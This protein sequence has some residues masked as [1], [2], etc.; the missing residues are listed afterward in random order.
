MHQADS[1]VVTS[2]QIRLCSS[3]GPKQPSTTYEITHTHTD[4]NVLYTCQV[5]TKRIN[6]FS[7]YNTPYMINIIKFQVF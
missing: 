1:Q 5:L 3:I 2:V 6:S 7:F 4:T